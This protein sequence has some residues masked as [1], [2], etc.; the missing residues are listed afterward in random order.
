M[1]DGV[2]RITT[3]AYYNYRDGCRKAEESGNPSAR[4]ES[5]MPYSV[6]SDLQ[7]QDRDTPV[8]PAM[9]IIAEC[10]DPLELLLM[11]EE[12]S[13]LE[14]ALLFLDTRSRYVINSV[15]GVGRPKITASAVGAEL[16]I[17]GERVRMI[18]EKALKAMRIRMES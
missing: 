10:R 5:P 16:G 2:C 13:D 1:S 18:K 4:P 15:F 17:S 14:N 7:E 8:F 11:R 3:R 6:L 9:K 12:D